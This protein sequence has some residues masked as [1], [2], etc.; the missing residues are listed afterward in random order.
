M[1]YAW[2][3]AVTFCFWNILYVQGTSSSRG[4]R[5][6]Q[7][8]GQENGSCYRGHFFFFA[9]FVLFYI[10]PVAP[11]LPVWEVLLTAR[12]VQVLCQRFRRK[13]A[14]AP[15]NPPVQHTRARTMTWI[16][17]ALC[18]IPFPACIYKVGANGRLLCSVHRPIFF[19]LAA[20]CS[21]ALHGLRIPMSC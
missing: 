1:F 6:Y 18:T 9:S 13:L 7:I 3:I 11:C 16:S 20:R 8:C 4:S 12:F 10:A 17:A 19:N 15:V 5:M 14:E 21:K 2:G